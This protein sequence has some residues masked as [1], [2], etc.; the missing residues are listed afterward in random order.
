MSE[1]NK[2]SLGYHPELEYKDSYYS[3][4]EYEKSTTI[5]RGV[6]GDSDADIRNPIEDLG[7]RIEDTVFKIVTLPDWLQIPVRN[8]FDPL[9]DIY[10]KELSGKEWDERYD[11]TEVDYVE[12]T[13]NHYGDA[14][15]DT[16]YESD[17]SN[18][19][20]SN[21]GNDYEEDLNTS[22]E[23]VDEDAFWDVTDFVDIE[24]TENDLLDV[25][26]NSYIKNVHDLI[27]EYVEG[28]NVALTDFWYTG[29]SQLYN[30]NEEKRELMNAQLNLKSSDVSHNHR[31]LVDYCRRN[32]ITRDMRSDFMIN[33]FS[34]NETISHFK[35]FKIAY[36]M[37]KKYASQ[38]FLD[39]SVMKGN[40]FSNK[41][42]EAS[43]IS[44]DAKYDRA[45]ER[46]YKYLIS[47]VDVYDDI[48]KSCLQEMRCKEALYDG[49]GILEKDDTRSN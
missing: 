35:A 38:E 8:V 44:V 29:M 15:Y 31:H 49:K 22:D 42:L 48:L 18:G 26:E 9:Y 45:F 46:A 24:I 27:T 39:G 16:D 17:G 19:S 4:L 3:E 37:K 40:A 47:S 30:I 11:V 25:L 41:V 7:Q 20:G 23:R 32:E 14:E 36:E 13:D 1:E 43:L 2:R 21:N 33:M 5:D 10:E 28:L 34:F 6:T 12:N